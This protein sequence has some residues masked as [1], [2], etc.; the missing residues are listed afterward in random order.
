MACVSGVDMAVHTG[1][2]GQLLLLYLE[3]S[4]IVVVGAA[5]NF[6]SA[7]AVPECFFLMCRF[8]AGPCG[9]TWCQ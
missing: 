1:E 6:T 3:T 8:R 9:A 5:V 7:V 2:Y 4:I